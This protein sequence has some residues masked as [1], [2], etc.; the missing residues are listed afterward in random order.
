MNKNYLPGIIAHNSCPVK[1]YL[2]FVCGKRCVQFSR[3]E[4]RSSAVAQYWHQCRITISTWHG[5]YHFRFRIVLNRNRKIKRSFQSIKK[6]FTRIKKSK[7]TTSTTWGWLGAHVRAPCSVVA[8]RFRCSPIIPRF[9]V[10]RVWFS[11]G[12]KLF[13]K[14]GGFCMTNA[15]NLVSIWLR[16]DPSWIIVTNVYLTR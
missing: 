14:E 11:W 10:S 8:D 15:P 9:A 6:T 7:S 12:A 2:R 13:R 3:N 1:T 5:F 16:S 4:R